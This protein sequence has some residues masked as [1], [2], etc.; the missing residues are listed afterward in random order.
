[1]H[2]SDLGQRSARSASQTYCLFKSGR[3]PL[4]RFQSVLE[5]VV[6]DVWIRFGLAIRA[7]RSL[8]LL[9]QLFRL[10]KREVFL[11]IFYKEIIVFIIFLI[12]IKP[13]D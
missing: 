4:G 7:A 8:P 9:D 1:M 11:L 6:L 5:N 2:R 12:I 13:E 3:G 10:L